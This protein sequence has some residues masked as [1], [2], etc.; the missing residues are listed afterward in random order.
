[1]PDSKSISENYDPIIRKE[2]K[3]VSKEKLINTNL[4]E[5]KSKIL[6]HYKFPNSIL[7]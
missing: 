1:L 7:L 6:K 2:S 5:S 4:N 3:R